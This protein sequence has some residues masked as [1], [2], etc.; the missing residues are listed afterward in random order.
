MIKLNKGE[1]GLIFSPSISRRVTSTGQHTLRRAIRVQKMV[2][3]KTKLADT[4]PKV[5]NLN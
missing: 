4:Y 1:L 5:Y 2:R 3:I